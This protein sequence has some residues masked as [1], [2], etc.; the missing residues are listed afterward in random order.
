MRRRK[1]AWCA[2]IAA[3][4][5][6]AADTPSDPPAEESAPG[7]NA[8]PSEE[9]GLVAPGPGVNFDEGTGLWLE[10]EAPLQPRAPRP[11]APRG[12]RP[13]V[14]APRGGGLGLAPFPRHLP[15]ELGPATARTRTRAGAGGGGPGAPSGPRGRPRAHANVRLASLCFFG[16]VHRTHTLCGEAIRQHFPRGE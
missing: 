10:D 1:G 3:R 4:A 8:G 5:D 9:Y 14:L 7:P 13:R 12:L 15:G 2:C 6:G 11:A 16:I